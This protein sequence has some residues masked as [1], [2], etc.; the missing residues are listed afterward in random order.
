MEATLDKLDRIYKTLAVIGLAI[1]GLIFAKD[2]VMPIAF[3]ALFSMVLL[4]LAK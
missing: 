4:P 1:A 3:G 2:I